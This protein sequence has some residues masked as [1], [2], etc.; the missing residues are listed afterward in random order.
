MLGGNVELYLMDN[1]YLKNRFYI[2]AYPTSFCPLLEDFRARLCFKRYS[3]RSSQ[4]CFV[5]R[6]T[7][8]RKEINTKK[9]EKTLVDVNKF[10]SMRIGIASPQK[11]VTGHLVKSKNQK[12]STIV[13]KNLNAKVSSMSVSLVHKRTGNVLVVSL[14][15]FST[16]TKSANSVVFK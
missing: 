11:F 2:A 3:E 5:N 1:F 4:E 12:P 6:Q 7:F 13:R 16:K 9:V 14:K 15:A 10:E 8:N